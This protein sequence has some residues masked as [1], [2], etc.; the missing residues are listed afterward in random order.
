MDKIAAPHRYVMDI[1]ILKFIANY[2]IK[3][4]ALI[5]KSINYCQPIH[6]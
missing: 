1:P 3:F 4:N 5:L 2:S 6:I